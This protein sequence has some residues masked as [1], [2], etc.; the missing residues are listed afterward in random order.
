[1]F[2]FTGGGAPP[3]TL[4]FGD[5]PTRLITPSFERDLIFE[6]IDP[7]DFFE[8]EEFTDDAEVADDKE[9]VEEEADDGGD[10]ESESRS[11]ESLKIMG[12][13][14]LSSTSERVEGKLGGCEL[15]E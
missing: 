2:R 14:E 12:S 1:V 6:D 8:C 3:P 7:L 5:P 15:W 13:W 10:S 9:E 4:R 11:S